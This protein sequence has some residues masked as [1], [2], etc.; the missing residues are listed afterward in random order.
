MNV[1]NTNQI[2]KKVLGDQYNNLG[3]PVM[4]SDFNV[5]QFEVNV[6]SIIAY[7]GASGAFQV[8]ETITGGS[9]GATAVIVSDD[10]FALTI[11]TLV[12][13]FTLGETITGSSSEVTATITLIDVPLYSFA[14]LSSN[15]ILPPDI[16]IPSSDTNKYE[17][18][19]YTDESDST[20]Y[21]AGN[22]FSPAGNSMTK[23][24]NIEVT[25][26]RWY[27]ITLLN[28]GDA[29]LPDVDVSLFSF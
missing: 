15:Q 10:G 19:G 5:A 25:G 11:K 14:V 2:Y 7:S 22:E 26:S 9:S 29:S 16:T 24:F 12:G 28:Q 27:F 8:G 18:V 1:Y 13:T 6:K 3:G 17:E 21:S 20:Y 4:G 23:K